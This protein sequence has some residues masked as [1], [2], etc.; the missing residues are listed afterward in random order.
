L[1]RQFVKQANL[2]QFVDCRAWEDSRE[3]VGAQ[4]WGSFGG[5]ARLDMSF[6]FDLYLFCQY[7]SFIRPYFIH[8]S[9]VE[10][11]DTQEEFSE[12]DNDFVNATFLE[13]CC[14][15]EDDSL[16][17]MDFTASLMGGLGH[18]FNEEEDLDVEEA[19][20]TRQGGTEIITTRGFEVGSFNSDDAFI[21]SFLDHM[22]YTPPP[23]TFTP[24]RDLPRMLARLPAVLHPSLFT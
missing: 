20:N 24:P 6:P 10:P 19:Y 4:I 7:D 15:W 18:A 8:W 1:R 11:P 14:S 22:S 5:Q 13:P 3:L 9:M 23:A 17:D 12:A 2:T 16:Q 21:E